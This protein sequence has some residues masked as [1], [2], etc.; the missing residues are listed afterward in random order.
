MDLSFSISRNLAAKQLG[1][2]AQ[3]RFK[4]STEEGFSGM[5]IPGISQYFL[6]LEELEF[7]FKTFI[8]VNCQSWV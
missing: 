1:V 8:T 4:E 3:S 7:R 5:D 6:A 2:I